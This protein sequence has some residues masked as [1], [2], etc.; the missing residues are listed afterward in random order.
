MK[1]KIILLLMTLIL[2]SFLIFSMRF[3]Y[4]EPETVMVVPNSD[5]NPMIVL[6]DGGYLIR[7]W[8]FQA[9]CYRL[10]KIG[11]IQYN[12]ASPADPGKCASHET[13]MALP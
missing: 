9:G 11:I 8:G 13:V 10:V 1:F 5:G 3:E 6:S 4:L 2:T 12:L 7:D